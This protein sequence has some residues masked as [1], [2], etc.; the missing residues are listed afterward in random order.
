MSDNN[1][2]E[3]E[4]LKPYWDKKW[5]GQKP[6][7]YTGISYENHAVLAKYLP[8]NKK[9]A[10]LEIGCV[11]GTFLVYLNKEFG[12]KPFGIDN[13]SMTDLAEETLKINNIEGVIWT[14]DAFTFPY[15]SKFD[16][17]YSGGFVEHFDDYQNVLDLHQNLV[18]EKGYLVIT[19]P[20]LFGVHGIM[21]KA[22]DPVGYHTHVLE[23]TKKGRVAEL[24]SSDF[25]VLYS[26]YCITYRHYYHLPAP[27]KLIS[28]MANKALRVSGMDKIPNGWFS[29]HQ[30]II[31]RRK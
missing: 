31:A 22:F 30:L 14:G 23:L 6:E 13:S 26:D 19:V 16:V 29:P 2:F 5:N 3:N 7:L 15:P 21:M 11:P 10:A 28:R 24:L 9:F 12:Y 27:L 20:N 18:K 4:G 25:E 8:I 17:V 1:V